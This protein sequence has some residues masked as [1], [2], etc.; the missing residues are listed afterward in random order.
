MS[1]VTLVVRLRA[2]PGCAAQLEAVVRAAVAPSHADP[3]CMR[4]AVHKSKSDPDVF[5]LIERW[6]SQ[7]ALDAHMAQPFLQEM[8]KKAAALAEPAEVAAYDMVAEGNPSKL[9]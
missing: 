9:L 1:E 8:L 6:A 5:L 3:A 7:P 2:K 4:Y